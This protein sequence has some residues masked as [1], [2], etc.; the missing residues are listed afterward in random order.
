MIKLSISNIAWTV[1]LDAEMNQFLNEVGFQGLEIA[2]SRI[3]PEA[4]YDK[5]SEAKAWVVELREKIWVASTIHA[6]HM[7]WSS[8]KD[9]WF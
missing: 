7:V 4:P 8:R 6:I 3:F 1:E 5:L 2:P 9:L